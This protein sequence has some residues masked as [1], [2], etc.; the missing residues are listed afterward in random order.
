MD[1]AQTLFFFGVY[2]T[3]ETLLYKV[4][5]QPALLGLEYLQGKMNHLLVH[6][7]NQASIVFV[8]Q[9]TWRPCLHGDPLHHAPDVHHAHPPDPAGLFSEGAEVIKV[10][11]IKLSNDTHS[12]Y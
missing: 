1:R 5:P 3:V 4:K 12:R 7:I 10:A 6:A 11:Y 8:Y 9:Y 2:T